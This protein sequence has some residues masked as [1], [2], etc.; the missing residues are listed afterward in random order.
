MAA[1]IGFAG[2]TG[3]FILLAK[4]LTKLKEI[5][6]PFCAAWMNSASSRK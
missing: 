2:I 6:V 5:N 4:R 3:M 1:A